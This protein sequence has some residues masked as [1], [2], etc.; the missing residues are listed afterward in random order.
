MPHEPSVKE[1]KERTEKVLKVDLVT[2]AFLCSSYFVCHSHHHAMSI[3]SIHIHCF[4]LGSSWPVWH[5]HSVSPYG[6]PTVCIVVLCWWPSQTC[7]CRLLWDVWGGSSVISSGKPLQDSG[8]TFSSCPC[9]P[10][11]FLRAWATDPVTSH[12]SVVWA[13]SLLSEPFV[14][15][16][17]T[18]R[19]TQAAGFWRCSSLRMAIPSPSWPS[20]LRFPLKQQC[21]NRLGE[22]AWT[23]LYDLLP[24]IEASQSWQGEVAGHWCLEAS[25]F[26]CTRCGCSAITPEF[27]TLLFTSQ[28]WCFSL[29]PVE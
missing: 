17:R 3:F 29:L 11:S 16:A 1:V 26:L 6:G 5:T 19:V 7:E 20:L 23:Q 15:I 12:H 22:A 18:N 14:L 21:R 8:K 2:G 13:S 25:S 9:V 10:C 28:P 27:A 24:P 4:H